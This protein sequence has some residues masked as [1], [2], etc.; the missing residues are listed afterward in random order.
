[1]AMMPNEACACAKATRYLSREIVRLKLI[2]MRMAKRFPKVSRSVPVTSEFHFRHTRTLSL[3]THVGAIDRSAEA[4][5][6]W[7]DRRLTLSGAANHDDFS[8]DV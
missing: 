2:S 6:N 4:L 1:M 7:L 5:V 3:E 8:S